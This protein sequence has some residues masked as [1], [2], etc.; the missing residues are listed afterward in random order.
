M[1]FPLSRKHKSTES[2]VIANHDLA[3]RR[4]TAILS[5]TIR[6]SEPKSTTMSAFAIKTARSLVVARHFTLWL[7]ARR[8]KLAHGA[9]SR[10]KLLKSVLVDDWSR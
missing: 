4:K 6:L 3:S 8:G 1:R 10:R 2:V 5:S 9:V 7:S